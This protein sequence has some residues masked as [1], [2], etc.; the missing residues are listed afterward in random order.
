MFTGTSWGSVGVA[1]G[2]STG[3][4][5]KTK[6]S[7]DIETTCPVYVRLGGGSVEDSVSSACRSAAGDVRLS[8]A[9]RLG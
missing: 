3:G 5:G 4:K 2:L 8:L 6:D 7:R 9:S 1:S